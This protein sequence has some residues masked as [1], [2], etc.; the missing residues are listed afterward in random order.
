M[1]LLIYPS[2]YLCDCGHQLDVFENTVNQ[3]KAMSRRSRKAHAI[4]GSEPVD[5][6]PF[7]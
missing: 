2:S 4:G 3:M 5:V 6:Q 1:A 7:F